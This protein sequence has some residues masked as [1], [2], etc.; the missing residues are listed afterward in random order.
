MTLALN[1]KSTNH[2]P[3]QIFMLLGSQHD[4]SCLPSLCEAINLLL[5][6]YKYII[7]SICSPTLTFL[8]SQ[9]LDAFFRSVFQTRQSFGRRYQNHFCFSSKAERIGSFLGHKIYTGGR[10]EFLQFPPCHFLLN[11]K[12]I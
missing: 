9:S 11:R 10:V 1:L 7:L 2:T 12:E 5:V 8:L 4:K 6:T 3:S